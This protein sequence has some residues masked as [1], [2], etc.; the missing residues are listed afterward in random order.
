[1]ADWDIST[2]SEEFLVALCQKTLDEEGSI[3]DVGGIPVVKISPHIAAKIGRRVTASEAVTQ[4]FA[5]KELDPSSIVYVPKVYRYFW[6]SRGASRDEYGYLFMEYIPGRKLQTLE[7]AALVELVPRVVK[8]IEHLGQIRDGTV[9]GPVGGGVLMGH[10]FGDDGAKTSFDSIEQMNAYINKRLEYGNIYL[11]RHRGIEC[12]DT[13]DL[14]PYPLVLC[15]GDICRR[16]LILR[17]DGSLCLL[18][19]GYAGFYPRFFEVVALTCTMPYLDVFEG[20]LEREAEGMMQLT[21]EE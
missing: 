20:A 8:I 9:P 14:T 17:E 15:H 12:N 13:I 1:M 10:I 16:N 11:A 21:D 4:A 18:D 6:S 5:H 19:W 3:G 7:T 2:A